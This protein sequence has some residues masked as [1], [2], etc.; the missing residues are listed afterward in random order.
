MKV[1]TPSIFLG[2]MVNKVFHTSA[3][4]SHHQKVPSASVSLNSF[5]PFQ[6]DGDGP[7]ESKSKDPLS[8][9]LE[10]IKDVKIQ[11]GAV[12][13]FPFDTRVE[14][15]QILLRTEKRPLNCMVELLQGPNNKRQTM[16]IY[17]ENGATRPYYGILETPG[18]GNVVR[19]TNI[20]R[21][22]YPV[23]AKVGP[24]RVYRGDYK[25]TDLEPVIGGD[26]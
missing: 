11:G 8:D 7:N 26:F 21:L 13:T 3:F 1:L 25:D 24:F 19:I 23:F 18:S 20:A 2:I 16:E 22:E 10:D 6:Y 5:S 17:T 9:N 12:K 15:I 14:S 4:L